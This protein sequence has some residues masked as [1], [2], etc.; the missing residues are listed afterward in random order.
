MVRLE[1]E[2]SRAVRWPALLH[3]HE[4][5]HHGAVVKSGEKLMYYPTV[6]PEQ[7]PAQ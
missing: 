1:E 5:G 6:H 3:R 4:D 7:V 2:A